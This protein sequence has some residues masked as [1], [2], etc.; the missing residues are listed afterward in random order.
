MRCG[1]LDQVRAWRQTILL[2]ICTQLYTVRPEIIQILYVLHSYRDAF[3]NHIFHLIIIVAIIIPK[4]ALCGASNHTYNLIC[5]KKPSRGG[6][7]P[8]ML[9]RFSQ[10]L[11]DE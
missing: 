7:A 2:H 6:M 10:C 8:F 3:Y 9:L 11:H 1:L 4:G 5:K